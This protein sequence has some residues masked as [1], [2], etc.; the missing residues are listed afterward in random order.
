M[1]ICQ[2]GQ[3]VNILLKLGYFPRT[4]ISA[5]MVHVGVLQFSAL[6]FQV[7]PHSIAPVLVYM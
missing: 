5:I 4:D 7:T 6:F 2:T 1:K 3:T